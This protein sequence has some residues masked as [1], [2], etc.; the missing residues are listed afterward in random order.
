AFG[1]GPPALACVP[2]YR[3]S[4]P[5]LGL[6]ARCEFGDV[7]RGLRRVAVRVVR[8]DPD[9]VVAA[10]RVVEDDGGVAPLEVVG[11]V[12]VAVGVVDQQGRVF[13]GLDVDVEPAPARLVVEVHVRLGV[14]DVAGAAAAGDGVPVPAP[15][16]YGDG[17]G[18]RRKAGVEGDRAEHGLGAPVGLRLHDACAEGQNGHQGSQAH[19]RKGRH[20]RSR[21]WGDGRGY[22]SGAGREPVAA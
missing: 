2:A 8:P 7:N 17:V 10:G 12:P 15:R 9:V 18:V 11:A 6:P 20:H 21:G 4:A 13:A 3:L 22:L 19:R 5:G 16:T 1:T 14:V